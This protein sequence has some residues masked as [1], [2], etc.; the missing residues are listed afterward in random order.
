M[1]YNWFQN[2]E[3]ANAWVLWTLLALPLIVFIYFRTAAR[4]HATLMVTSAESY[5]VKTFRNTF[6]HFP[7]F[8]RI[9]AIACV[10]LA[11]AKPQFK[12]VKN[13]NKGEGIDI[14]LCLDVSGSMLSPD[15][16]PNRLEVAK[17]MAADFVKGRPIDQI[18]L[19]IFAGEPYTQ[20]PLSTDHAT[21]LSHISGLRSGMLEDGTVIGEGLATS[22]DR[23][24]QSKSKSKVIILLTD[25][26]EEAPDTRLIDPHTALEIAKSKGVKV[27]TIGMGAENAMLY[28]ETGKKM[29]RGDYFLDEALM[30]RIASQ[31][32]GEYFRATNKESLEAI[33]QRIDRMEKTEVEVVT[34]TRFDELFIYFILGALVFL[35]LEII[36]R[37][38]T[39]RTFP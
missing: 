28:T 20:F 9:L 29:V 11:L 8:L 1:L 32:G 23:L 15:F 38:T 19:V 27:Y 21:L 7:F 26:K 36:L 18:G 37:F 25:G 33:Y 16:S 31:T 35:T 14:I 10:I 30:K 39:F 24:S 12:N 4:K 17:Q 34:K 13:R 3:F 5:T 2:I 6:F 22:V